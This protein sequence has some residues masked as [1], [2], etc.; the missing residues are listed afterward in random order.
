[1]EEHPNRIAID[2]GAYRSGVLTAIGL[3]E[4]ER[5]FIQAR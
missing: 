5:W 1:V 4:G 2:T 3:E